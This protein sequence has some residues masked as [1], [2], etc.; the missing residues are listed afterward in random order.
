MCSSSE[1]LNRAAKCSLGENATKRRRL[2]QSVMRPL[3]FGYTSFVLSLGGGLE[4]RYFLVLQSKVFNNTGFRTI[5]SRDHWN[6]CLY[7]CAASEEE[8]R[9]GFGFLCFSHPGMMQK[10]WILQFLQLTANPRV[11][12]ACHRKT[13]RWSGCSC[14]QRQWYRSARREML[15]RC[16]GAGVHHLFKA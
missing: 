6:F 7:W 12:K 13:V 8:Y 11:R 3:A 9:F 5:W 10:P 16:R 14:A 15:V 4:Q 1:N 2:A